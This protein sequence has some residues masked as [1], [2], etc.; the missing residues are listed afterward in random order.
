MKAMGEDPEAQLCCATCYRA[1]WTIE[2]NTEILEIISVARIQHHEAIADHVATDWS[3]AP[4]NAR[5]ATFKIKVPQDAADVVRA[6][7]N[8]PCCGIPCTFT[9]SGS[10][11]HTLL[12]FQ[13]LSAVWA[14]KLQRN[15]LFHNARMWRAAMLPIM[16][17]CVRSS[18]RRLKEW[19][20]MKEMT[21]SHNKWDFAKLDEG[22]TPAER[23]LA[24]D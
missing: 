1:S 12:H 2:K 21:L 22:N 23:N 7:S 3:V 8:L 18:A 20:M 4:K 11:N 6:E 5:H 15:V 14:I 10:E 17:P 19:V 13:T 16:R 24:T 9:I